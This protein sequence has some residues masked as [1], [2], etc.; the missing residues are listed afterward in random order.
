MSKIIK[1]IIALILLGVVLYTTQFVRPPAIAPSTEKIITTD[2]SIYNYMNSDI[3]LNLVGT[4]YSSI[5]TKL[6]SIEQS[7]TRTQQ[8]QGL[9]A[10]LKRVASPI[11]NEHYA[12]LII[13]LANQQ[14]VDF[15]IIV[16]LIGTE[17]GWCKAPIY[18]NCFGYLNKVHYTSF[19]D[20]FN[21][22]I[23]KISKQY[24]IHYGWN[25]QGFIKAYGQL[26]DEAAYNYSRNMYAITN[27]LF[28]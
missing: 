22:L 3:K 27:K 26:T 16:A 11:A 7:Q 18:Y 6:N 5:N 13:D 15:R 9:V 21:H 2:N 20:A 19:D 23:P 1:S 4:L 24:F 10:Y 17:S 12:S 8:I 25:L 14:G 28:Y